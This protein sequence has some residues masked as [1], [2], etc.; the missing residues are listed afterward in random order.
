MAVAF[1]S[2][3]IGALRV[4]PVRMDAREPSVLY[5]PVSVVQSNLKAMQR[6]D[7]G[8]CFKFLSPQFRQN[9]SP[10]SVGF[11]HVGRA[12]VGRVSMLTGWPTCL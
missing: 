7:V 3:E 12:H 1:L 4:R 9:L 5:S 8:S 10:I 11:R 2:L 6:D